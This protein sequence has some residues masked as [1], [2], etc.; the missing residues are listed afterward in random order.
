LPR[1]WVASGRPSL[2][3]TIP[4][5]DGSPAPLIQKANAWSLF[6]RLVARGIPHR[7][8]LY[9]DDLVIFLSTV[10]GDL[11]LIKVIFNIFEGASGLACNMN[12]SEMA[13]I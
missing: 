7:A 5:G 12:N 6:N 3:H 4:I 1:A 9:A 10:A 11:E 8:S 2:L 13:T